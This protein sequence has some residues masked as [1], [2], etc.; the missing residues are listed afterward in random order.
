MLKIN[1]E[2]VSTVGEK[3]KAEAEE[4]ENIMNQLKALE[5]DIADIWK[6]GDSY[7]FKVSFSSHNQELS[8]I[9]AFLKNHG[10]LLIKC[11]ETHNELDEDYGNAMSG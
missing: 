7:N 4:C 1:C 10:D 8:H 11:A 6:G 3:F 5:Q 9:T 2:V